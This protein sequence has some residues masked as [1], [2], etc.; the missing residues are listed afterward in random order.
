MIKLKIVPEI[1]EINVFYDIEEPILKDDLIEAL[2]EKG[3]SE[4][5]E[6]PELLNIGRIELERLTIARKRGCNI[7]YSWRDGVIGVVGN[8]FIDVLTTYEELEQILKDKEFLNNA[9]RF[10]HHSRVKVQIGTKPTS[11]IKLLAQA[12]KNI[13]LPQDKYTKLEEIFNM[14]LQ[15]FCIRLCPKNSEDFIGNLREYEN[16]LD[17]YIFPYITNTRY[18]S[19]WFVFR[20]KDSEKVKEFTRSAESRIKNILE[21]IVSDR[22]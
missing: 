2:K 18:L 3:F 1:V 11:T 5:S 9:K 8:K 4:I 15:P 7:N 20:D 19:I 14:K 22:I 13:F 21:V 17:V 6:E 10:E 16:W 12:F